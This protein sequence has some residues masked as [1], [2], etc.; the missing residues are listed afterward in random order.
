M[1]KRRPWYAKILLILTLTLGLSLFSGQKVGAKIVDEP[2]ILLDLSHSDSK[3]DCGASYMEYNER[4]I[5]N[6]ITLKVGDILVNKGFTVT[7]TRELDKS[8]SINDRIKLADSSDYWLY[9]SIHANSNEGKPGT[10]VEAYSNNEWT[11]SNNILN[12]LR[13]EFG[14]VKRSSPQATPWYNRKIANSTLLEIG[15]I[16]NDFDRDIMLNS[17]DKVA[18]I[19]A[20]NIINDYEVKMKEK[21][22]NLANT[23]GMKEDD[24]KLAN[25]VVTQE[26]TMYDGATV[27]IRITYY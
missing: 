20:N 19:I 2:I 5:V 14:L 8:V 3:N 18:E 15:F 1:L 23:V 27:P 9:L 12:D 21:E 6:S 16:N 7:Y 10:G 13:D 17:Q 4:D 11:L 26:M 22:F 25:N 24:S